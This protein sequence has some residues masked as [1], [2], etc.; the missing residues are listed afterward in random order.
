[1]TRI[2]HTPV[3]PFRVVE[4]CLGHSY[5]YATFP[6]IVDANGDEPIDLLSNEPGFHDREWCE[7][8]CDRLNAL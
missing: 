2:T 1:M 6:A 8:E 4:E 3:P 5:D 7:R